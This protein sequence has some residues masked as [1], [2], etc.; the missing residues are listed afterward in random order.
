MQLTFQ[1]C[2]PDDVHALRDF[3]YRTFND[4]FAPMNTPA[5]MQ[6]YLE[7]SFNTNKLHGEL[8]D[9]NSSFYFLYAGRELAGYLKLNESRHK[10]I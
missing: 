8:S 6:A 3:S 4:T 1:Q 10:L 7:Q 9:S 5:T 2:R